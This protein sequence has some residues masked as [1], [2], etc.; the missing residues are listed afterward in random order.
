MTPQQ[1]ADMMRRETARWSKVAQE[2][3]ISID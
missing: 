3:N 1:F 2:A